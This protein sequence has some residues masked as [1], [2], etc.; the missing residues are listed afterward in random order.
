MWKKI[1]SVLAITGLFF[2][3]TASALSVEDVPFDGTSGTQIIFDLVATPNTFAPASGNYSDISFR[4]GTASNVTSYVVSN[5]TGSIVGTFAQGVTTQLGNVRYR[6]YGTVGNSLTGTPLAFGVYKVITYVSDTQTNSILDASQTLVTLAQG[7]PTSN[8]PVVSNLTATPLTFSAED[9]EDTEITFDVNQDAYLTVSIIEDAKGGGTPVRTFTTYDGNDWYES[10][11]NNSVN[12]DGEDNDG[13]IVV[14]GTYYVEVIA[15]NDNG[16]SRVTTAVEVATEGP[17]SAGAIEDFTITPSGTWDPTDEELEIEFEIT[18][19]VRSLRID[20]KQGNRLIEILDDDYADDDEYTETWD[21]TDDDG[22]FVGEGAWQI[23]VRADG[24]LVSKTINIE[25]EQPTIIEAFVTKNSIDPS[26]DEFTTLV[27]KVDASSIVTVEVFEGNKKEF[28]LLD[29]ETV[30]KNKWYA[31]DWNAIDEEGDDVNEGQN[32]KFKITA[33]NS[34]DDDISDTVN[35]EIDV[36][37][38]EVSD[39]KS[40]VTNDTTYPTIFDKNSYGT[41]TFNYYIDEE[42]EVFL[43]IYDGT[44]TSGNSEIDLLNYV[45]FGAGWHSVE[46]D[47]KDE[48]N[49]ALDSGVYT[50]KFI[51]KASGN[52][53]DTEVGQFVVGTAGYYTYP[54]E[55]PV[56]PVDPSSPYCGGYTDTYYVNDDSLCSALEWATSEGIV[57][58]YRDG[59]FGPYNNINRAEVLKVVFE[60]LA[61]YNNLTILPLDST[62]QGFWDIAD[63]YAWYMPYVRT[64]KFYGMMQGYA[65]GSAGLDRHVSRVEVL[66]FALEGARAFA[67]YLIPTYPYSYYADVNMSDWFSAYAGVAYTYVL[68]DEYYGNGGTYLSPNVSVQ[69]GEVI[70]MLYRLYNNG[71]L[72]GGYYYDYSG[73]D[74]YFMGTTTTQYPL[75]Y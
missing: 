51:S 27:F 62:N 38:D 26:K 49:K 58:G 22:D 31:V 64:A 44:S 73:T 46:W 66:K 32:W 24:D 21:G 39:S 60:A 50:Y 57:H 45:S 7:E 16:T 20:A 65:D 69:R 5:T 2:T 29:E 8:A 55:P 35:V 68:F 17:G 54:P 56:D 18:D 63:T 11:E 71:V 15:E 75:Y 10:D 36:E 12:W 6:W 19:E 43:A 13:E 3:S 9:S 47:V 23:I 14:D 67:G 34:V 28:T 53:K 33:E 25:Y 74:T 72:N 48:N 41:M 52:H 30:S 4:L 37:E 1:L 59:S 61:K 40:N 42:A 70:E